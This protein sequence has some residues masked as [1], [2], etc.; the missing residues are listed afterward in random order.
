MRKGLF[1]ILFS[2]LFTGAMAGN[3]SNG[4]VEGKSSQK[5]QV[6]DHSNLE[7]LAGASIYIKELD[8][9]V[10]ADFDG[11][12]NLDGIPEGEYNLTVQLIS[13]DEKEISD[14]QIGGKS[15]IT[16]LRLKPTSL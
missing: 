11:Y 9:T 15:G 4:P 6:V 16:K 1:V 8:K 13:Y 5:I 10:F 7:S 3:G 12:V 14:F 2:F